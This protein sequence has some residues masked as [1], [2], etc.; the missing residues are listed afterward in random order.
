MSRSGCRRG[1]GTWVGRII[2]PGGRGGC[3][4]QFPCIVDVL[5]VASR[6]YSYFGAWLSRCITTNNS[7]PPRRGRCYEEVRPRRGGA[8]NGELSFGEPFLNSG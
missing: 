4:L 1:V 5:F 7:E 6:R 2:R 8:Q 3:F